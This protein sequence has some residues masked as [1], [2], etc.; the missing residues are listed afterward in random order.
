MADRDTSGIGGGFGAGTGGPNRKDQ[1]STGQNGTSQ[2]GSQPNATRQQAG[3]QHND[4][5]RMSNTDRNSS[6]SNAM[7]NNSTSNN[8]TGNN[9]S[10]RMTGDVSRM[11]DDATQAGRDSISSAQG[12]IRSLLEQQSH[13]AADQLGSV[14]NALHKAAEQL[15]DENNGAAARYAGQAAD[16]VEQVADM[17]RTSSVD[18]MVGQVERFAR[19]QP[20]VFVGAAFAV[21]FLFARFIKSSGDRRFQ[22]QGGYRAPTSRM[23]SDRMSGF[24]HDDRSSFSA[25]RSATAS[26]MGTGMVSGAGRDTGRGMAGGIAGSTAAGSSSAYDRNH[27]TAGAAPPRASLN[28]AT[29]ATSAA[30]TRDAAQ[31]VAG[32]T[33]TTGIGSGQTNQGQANQGSAGANSTPVT[34][35]KPQGT[36]P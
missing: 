11:A 10:D 17:L 6:A 12:R 27:A 35:V 16:R 31:L 28:A 34:G 13:R 2:P 36:L 19:R 15:N 18:D 4:M 9:P 25:G 3:G 32:S 1:N 30:R 14:A 5:G 26:G 22:G 29:A 21:G 33:G 7:G 20:E 8:S 23:T 24:G